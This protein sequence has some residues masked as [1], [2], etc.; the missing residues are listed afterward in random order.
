MSKDLNKISKYF[1]YLLRH[2]P[3]AIGLELDENGWT[4]IEELIKKTTDFTLNR[5][6][7]EVIVETNDKKRFSISED[8]L[9]IRANQGHSIEIDLDLQPQE[10]PTVL[11][12]GTAGKF[13]NAIREE[14]LKRMKRH[15]VHL[16]ESQAVAQ[17]VGSRYGQPILL[18][19][20]TQ[21]MYT[22]GFKFFKSAN[23]VW[24]VESVP[25][26]YIEEI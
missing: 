7:V 14:G 2:K 20:A 22:D 13:L 15:H 4:S 16:T 26:K 24:L 23:N 12:H 11:V 21:K 9:F 25:A 1:S 18:S 10:P 17:N 6:L 5:D 8:G 19:I 3:Q